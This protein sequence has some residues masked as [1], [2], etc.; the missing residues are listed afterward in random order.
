MTCPYCESA[1]TTER[2]DRTALGYR[3]FRC[4]TSKRGMNIFATFGGGP[5][6]PRTACQS[7]LD[8][9]AP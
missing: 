2:P 1:T 7:F 5:R 3:R 9:G 6:P 8:A 4:D